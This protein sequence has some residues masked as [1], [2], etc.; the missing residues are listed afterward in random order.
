MQKLIGRALLTARR[1]TVLAPGAVLLLLAGLAGCGD[2]PSEP[3]RGSLAVEISGVPAGTQVA[4]TVTGP[5][6]TRFSRVVTASE[7]LSDLAPG[8]YT[9]AASPITRDGV[10]YSPSNATQTVT[11]TGGKVPTPVSVAFAVSSGALSVMIGGIAGEAHPLVTVTGPNAYSTQLSTS[12][13]LVTLEPGLYTV[14]AQELVASYGTYVPLSAT[15]QVQVGASITPAVATVSYGITTGAISLNVSGL[16]AGVNPAI[17]LLGPNGYTRQLTESGVLGNLLPGSYTLSTGN[18]QAADGHIYS[19]T[20]V[21]QGFTIQASETPKVVTVTYKLAT[22]ALDVSVTGLPAGANAGV[23]V[24][25]PNGY[26]RSVTG[27][28]NLTGLFPGTYL[29]TAANVNA[30]AATYTPTPAITAHDVTAALAPRQANIAYSATGGPPPPAFNLMIE[31]MHVTQVVQTFAGDVPLVAGRPGL[32]RIF[33]RSTTAYTAQPSVRVRFYNGATLTQ[34]FFLTAPSTSVPTAISEGTLTSSWNALVPASLIQPGF[35]VLADVDPTNTIPEADEGDNSFP[36]H[37][38]PLALPVRVTSPLNVWFVPVKH[39]PTGATGNVT[40]QNMDQFLVMARKVLPIKDI[41]PRLHA[42]FSTSAPTVESNDASGAWVQILLEIEALRVAEGSADYHMGIINVS[43][44]N[45]VAGYG[46]APG[47]STVTWDRLPS[48]SPV[49]AHELGHN[50]GRSHAPCGGAANA[51]P[52]YPYLL[53]TIGVYGYDISLDQLKGTNTT[54][55]M[56]Y[57]G[58]GWISDYNYVGMMNYRTQTPGAAVAP[59]VMAARLQ[60]S[61]PVR[62]TTVQSSAV[63]PSLV[64]WGRIDNGRPVLEPAFAAVTRPVLPSRSGPHRIEA[65]D[66]AGRV[67]FSHAFEGDQPADVAGASVRTFA[68]AVPVDSAASESIVVLR[69]TSATGARAEFRPSG[70]SLG[71]PTALEATSS[72]P[73]E[74]SFRVR[75]PAVRLAVVRDRA[76][77]QI[78]AFVRGGTTVVRSRAVDFEVE[79]SDGRG[80]V[81]RMLRAVPR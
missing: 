20:P 40:E 35:H 3:L 53:G 39:G 19:A 73:G 61:S 4:V 63:R 67:L 44:A 30:G 46:F 13:T 47:R 71:G 21:S 55:L 31:G 48:A 66:G 74:V 65:L 69:L 32:L 10:R 54:D 77:R 42:V 64:V 1:H 11:V 51:D 22:G 8:T 7:T 6:G 18:A 15:Q 23:S 29:V 57:C 49:A 24:T 12:T 78:V 50:L 9:L 52:N 16:P 25:G 2:S 5:A 27:S 41:V 28:I 34:T 81:R 60:D 14:T 72:R 75:D 36:R 76:S 59:N 70:S 68:F 58:F 56:G 79:L 26:N 43:Y 80:S 38:S 17:T 45:G 33:V 37:G 62:E